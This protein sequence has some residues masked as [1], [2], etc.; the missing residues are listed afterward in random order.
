M[1]NSQFQYPHKAV[2]GRY[3]VHAD[4]FALLPPDALAKIVAAERLAKVALGQRFNVARFE[5]SHDTISL[6]HYPTFFEDPFPAL[7][8]S[9]HVDFATGRVSYRT[10]QDSLTPPILHRKE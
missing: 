6:L 8:E 4:A 5:T 9:W 3:Y 2:A 7:N 1:S 10:Y